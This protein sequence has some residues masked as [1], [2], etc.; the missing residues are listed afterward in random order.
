MELHPRITLPTALLATVVALLFVARQYGFVV[1]D[2]SPSRFGA[3]VP[4]LWLLSFLLAPVGV[5]VVGYL[6]GRGVDLRAAGWSLLGVLLAAGFVGY[7]V[8]T[9]GGVVVA[10]AV[11]PD[12]L[13]H[14]VA[15][16]ASASALT[17]VTGTAHVALAG[18]AGAALAA[19][20]GSRA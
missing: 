1:F 11:A 17:V 2:L 3:L 6:G 8:G 7:L 20:R 19:T 15:S 13:A 5:F 9:V 18:F 12:F 10:A 14:N 4:L 16:V